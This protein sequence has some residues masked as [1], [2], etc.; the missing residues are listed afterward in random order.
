VTSRRGQGV[1]FPTGKPARGAILAA[2]LTSKCHNSKESDML[3]LTAYSTAVF[4]IIVLM[5]GLLG[6]AL[7]LAIGA[8]ILRAYIVTAPEVVD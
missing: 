6:L 1:P 5:F 2:L 4:A 8:A 3:D 7:V